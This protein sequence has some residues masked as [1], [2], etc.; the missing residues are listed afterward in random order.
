MGAAEDTD[1]EVMVVAVVMVV[2]MAEEDVLERAMVKIRMNS[3][4][5]TEN[6][7]QKL[8]YTMQTNGYSSPH[9]KIIIFK[10]RKPVRYWEALRP[11]QKVKK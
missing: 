3:I 2:V 11:P 6:S 8:V 1:V 10:K 5:G 9:K 7:C 4:A